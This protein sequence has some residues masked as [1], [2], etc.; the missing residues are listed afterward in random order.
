MP[1]PGTFALFAFTLPFLVTGW[2][3]RWA[4]AAKR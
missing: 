1:E 3:R 2:R 4:F